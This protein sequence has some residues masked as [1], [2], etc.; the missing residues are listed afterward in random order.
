MKLKELRKLSKT[1]RLIL[2]GLFTLGFS[3]VIVM[4][5]GVVLFQNELMNTVQFIAFQAFCMTMLAVVSVVFNLF[6]DINFDVQARLNKI[7]KRIRKKKHEKAKAIAEAKARAA[8]QQ[9]QEM[10]AAVADA[11]HAAPNLQ[12][13]EMNG[14]RKLRKQA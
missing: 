7:L 6:K 12:L 5:T 13:I 14:H 4:V 8:Q 11:G 1:V 3:I 9:A 2:V 10:L